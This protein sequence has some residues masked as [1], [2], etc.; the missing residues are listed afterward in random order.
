MATHFYPL[1]YQ[2]GS[3]SFDDWISLF[4]ICLAP[5]IAHVAAVSPRPTC[6]TNAGPRWHDRMCLYNPTSIMW[7]YFA[8]AGRRVR[9]KAWSKLDLVTANAIFWT[10]QG[11]DGSENTAVQFHP[12]LGDD[13]GINDVHQSLLSWTTLQTVIVTLQGLQASYLLVGNNFPATGFVT[14]P[15]YMAFALDNIFLCISLLGLVRL[16]AAPWLTDDFQTILQSVIS[17]HRSGLNK[18]AASPSSVPEEGMTMIPVAQFDH[19]HNSWTRASVQRQYH[20]CSS[21]TSRAV[22]IVATVLAVSPIAMS[23]WQL[24]P[25]SSGEHY[26]V[27]ITAYLIFYLFL[28][29]ATGGIFIFYFTCREQSTTSTI[30]P[31][32]NAIW[33]KIY[34]V[35]LIALAVVLVTL[36]AGE[37]R[38]SPCG[39]YTVWPPKFDSRLCPGLASLAT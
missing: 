3:I 29:I 1:L 2:S 16:C 9:A 18:T 25:R 11:W 21:F 22:R 37:T 35:L 26:N 31:C 13:S 10:S 20:D 19:L 32:I 15:G 17:A 39:K 7:R 36:A 6:V 8:I 12:A 14:P 4:T 38:K 23:G 27:P 30:L 24:S 34:T 28:M 5:L 33:Y